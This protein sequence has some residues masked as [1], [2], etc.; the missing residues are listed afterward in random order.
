MD[1]IGYL[2]GELGY[3]DPGLAKC[4]YFIKISCWKK[5]LYFHLKLTDNFKE[6]VFMTDL[7]NE[8]IFSSTSICENF[9]IEESCT[10]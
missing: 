3:I 8:A 4:F 9:F 5:Y 1:K 7:Q 2:K 10:V 6:Y